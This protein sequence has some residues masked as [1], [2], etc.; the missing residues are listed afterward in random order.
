MTKITGDN[1]KRVLSREERRDNLPKSGFGLVIY[2]T[3]ENR[4]NGYV[5][6]DRMVNPRGSP[7]N[8]ILT[9]RTPYARKAGAFRC[10][11]RLRQSVYPCR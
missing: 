9:L 8:G 11:A 2:R 7:G 1:A 5:Q 6:P 3:D 10:C 4:N